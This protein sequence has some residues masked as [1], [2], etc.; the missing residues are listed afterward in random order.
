MKAVNTTTLAS[1]NATTNATGAYQ[2]SL[3]AGTYNVTATAINYTANRTYTLVVQAAVNHTE[4]DFRLTNC[5][6]PS[7]GTS[8]TGPSRS[9]V[10]T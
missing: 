5:W 10:S 1:F 9:A 2:L 8:P 6:A 4:I 3:P 7:R